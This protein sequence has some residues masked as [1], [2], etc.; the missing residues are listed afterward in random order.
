MN[1]SKRDFVSSYDRCGIAGECWEYVNYNS[2]LQTCSRKR[3]T[4]SM[5]TLMCQIFGLG[6]GG[7]ILL[8][9]LNICMWE[10]CSEKLMVEFFKKGQGLHICSV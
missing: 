10:W 6:A 3:E 7:Y 1:A 2:T 8:G 4:A 9:V 5:I